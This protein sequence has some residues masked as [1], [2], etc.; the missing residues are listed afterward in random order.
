MPGSCYRTG[1]FMN[2]TTT[3]D[4][5]VNDPATLA[6]A[7]RMIRVALDRLAQRELTRSDVEL[8]A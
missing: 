2:D 8:A 1:I 4:L 3:V 5:A 6:E 7:G